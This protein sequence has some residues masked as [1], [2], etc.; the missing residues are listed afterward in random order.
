MEPSPPSRR[1]P[2]LPFYKAPEHVQTSA[3]IISEAKQ[4][5]NRSHLK[6]V[7]TRRPVTPQESTRKLFGE[8]SVRDPNNRPPSAIRFANRYILQTY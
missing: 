5:I 2:D 4:T 8:T 1:K 3:K 7:S 6:S